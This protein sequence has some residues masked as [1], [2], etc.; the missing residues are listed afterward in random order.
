MTF[1][2]KDNGCNFWLVSPKTGLPL[3]IDIYVQEINLAIEYMREQH[4]RESF[5]DKNTF[6]IIKYND[7]MKRKICK[8]H[9]VNV[10]DVKYTWMETEKVIIDILHKNG[11]EISK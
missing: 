10:I 4:Y 7:K 9:D 1:S 2:Q 8:E 3:R 11:I 5:Y 6:G